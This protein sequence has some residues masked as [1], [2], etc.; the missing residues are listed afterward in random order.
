MAQE[1]FLNPFP[2]DLTAEKIQ[3]NNQAKLKHEF[4]TYTTCIYNRCL[5]ALKLY[6]ALPISVPIPKSIELTG[7]VLTIASADR[8]KAI[9]LIKSKFE[10]D[11]HY[12]VNMEKSEDVS[13]TD[14]FVIDFKK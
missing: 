10:K 11:G 4:Q 2:I 12:V 5:S 14:M 9:D 1:D 3:E 13:E 7:G 6:Q 8:K